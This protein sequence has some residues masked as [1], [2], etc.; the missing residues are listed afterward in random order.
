MVYMYA[1][2]DTE[3]NYNGTL[4]DGTAKTNLYH[5]GGTSLYRYAIAVAS[6]PITVSSGARIASPYFVQGIPELQFSGGTWAD[7]IIPENIYDYLV[8]LGGGEEKYMEKVGDMSK[9]GI[10]RSFGYVFY[11]QLYALNVGTQHFKV[12]DRETCIF[13]VV[14]S[15]LHLDKFYTGNM[16]EDGLSHEGDYPTGGGNIYFLGRGGRYTQTRRCSCLLMV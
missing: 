4:A 16:A 8:G 3:A 2:T 10:K 14:Q 15:F 5:T 13:A 7:P 1:S 11:L 6:F 12:P 9:I